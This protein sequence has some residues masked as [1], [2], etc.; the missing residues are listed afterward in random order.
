MPTAVPQKPGAI[1]VFTE[2]LPSVCGD[3][4]DFNSQSGVQKNPDV[5]K[6]YKGIGNGNEHFK[7][8]DIQGGLQFQMELPRSNKNEREK[9]KKRKNK[10]LVVELLDE[11]EVPEA[12]VPDFVSSAGNAFI[13]FT[14][15]PSE[16]DPLAEE[17]VMEDDATTSYENDITL[18]IKVKCRTCSRPFVVDDN[19]K[20]LSNVDN[21][22]LLYHI[23]LITGI[24]IQCNDEIS[25]FMCSHCVD[26]LRKAI[27]FRETCIRT[28]LLLTGGD[29]VDLPEN[30]IELCDKDKVESQT[31]DDI[32]EEELIEEANVIEPSTRA[33]SKETSVADSRSIALGA[34]I[35]EEL[36]S[37]YQAKKK[38]P[39]TKQKK[40][41]IPNTQST[42][43]GEKIRRE[44]ALKRTKKTREEK[45]RIR[46]EQNKALPRNHVCD[47]CGA[48]F[49]F[50]CNLTI[51]MLRHT[52]T[53]NYPCPECPK[54]FYDAY[55]RN[56]HIRVRHRGEHPFVCNYCSKAFKDGNL[57]YLH[58]KN[59]HG[60][61]PRIHRNVNELNQRIGLKKS[62][63]QPESG[64]DEY[65]RH[66]C[67]YCDKSYVT[68]CA[69][70][71]HIN[72][73]L[74]LTPY[75]CKSCDM[76][77]PNPLAKNRH[78]MR[79]DSKRPF[80]CDICL[81]GFYTRIKLKEHER[82]HT[83]ERPYRCDI[84]DSF[85]RYQFNLHSHQFSKMH[86][87]NLLK[88]QKEKIVEDSSSSS[89]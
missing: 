26:D 21:A 57:R 20:D 58:E 66:C 50:K 44:P 15:A 84:C 60:A 42:K 25:R 86:K 53:K 87:D 69:L 3:V 59:D 35:Y 18:P 55:M 49:R 67:S 17:Q 68:K 33:L 12:A 29:D 79:H 7:E 11:A 31:T 6:G 19:A 72:Q 83:G 62:Q 27:E 88:V 74:G 8:K 64:V 54:Q 38:T 14:S 34:Q 46:R 45:N 61:S 73:H 75:K 2:H 71:W 24:W 65:G 4:S 63:T 37:K 16:N 56:M 32:K 85:F 13:P 77:F 5:A 9:L 40:A 30:G 28:E 1:Q 89:E 36:L 51:H 39:Q 52:R 47:Q 22:V 76:S 10:N 80:E 48:S 70:N 43:K 82:I 41:T 78:E 23:E 81:K